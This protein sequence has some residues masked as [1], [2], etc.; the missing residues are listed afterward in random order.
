MTDSGLPLR[1]DTFLHCVRDV[2]RC[3]Q[4]LRELNLMWR[5]VGSAAKIN[6]PIKA[7]II[8]PTVAV[9]REACHRLEQDLVANLVN[10]KAAT[11]LD[12]L[13]QKPS[14]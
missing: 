13:A 4:S 9:T 3:E 10:E 14:M 11:V 5:M 8:W 2:T 1:I 7:K 12:Q 6:G